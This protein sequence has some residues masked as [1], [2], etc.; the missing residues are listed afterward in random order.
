MTT[1]ATSI[2]PKRLV[3]G[4]GCL[5]GL[6]RE[7]QRWSGSRALLV[8]DSKI[9]ATEGASRVKAAAAEA[10]LTVDV[11]DRVEENPSDQTTHIAAQ[12]LLES[13]AELVLGLG[14]GSVLDC[15]KSANII[16][17]NGRLIGDYDLASPNRTRIEKALPWV[18][19]PTT[20]G[21]GSEVCPVT[22]VTDS[23]RHVKYSVSS[24]RLIAG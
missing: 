13:G 5:D 21:T 19:I 24:P 15:A 22:V 20:A 12:A 4:T 17:C 18:S 7:L 11:F 6:S 1:F 2:W 14:G 23:Q 9:G 10:G 3:F 16:A 8:T